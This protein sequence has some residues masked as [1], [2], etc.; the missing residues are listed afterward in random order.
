MQVPHSLIGT[1]AGIGR[2][3]LQSWYLGYIASVGAFPYVIINTDRYVEITFYMR[4]SSFERN[5]IW[6][7]ILYTYMG[8]SPES[9]F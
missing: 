6:A 7:A 9:Y 5:V 4:G 2:I 3:P 1:Y 8:V